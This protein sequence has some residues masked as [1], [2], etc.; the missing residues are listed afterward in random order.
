MNSVV[1]FRTAASPNK[2]PLQAGFLD[3]PYKPF[4]VGV[5]MGLRGGNFTE[6]TPQSASVCKNSVVDNGSRS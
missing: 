4:G 3:R 1:A 2:I 6:A 5:Q